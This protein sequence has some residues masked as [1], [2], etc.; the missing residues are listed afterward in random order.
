MHDHFD[1]RA[2]RV[3][4]KVNQK[5]PKAYKRDI[6]VSEEKKTKMGE[7][8]WENMHNRKH[9]KKPQAFAIPNP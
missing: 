4:G 2:E 1:V 8:K 6:G 9:P 5:A 7:Q 3:H